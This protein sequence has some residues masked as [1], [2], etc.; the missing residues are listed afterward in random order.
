M[1]HEDTFIHGPFNFATVQ[2]RMTRDRIGQV[3]LQ[4][5]ANHSHMYQNSVPSF[6]VPTYS[7]HVNNGVHF[8]FLIVIMKCFLII[9]VMTIHCSVFIRV[10]LMTVVPIHCLVVQ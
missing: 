10:T 8:R 9:I 7:I 3:D 1:F 4:A 2:N 5:L 6:D